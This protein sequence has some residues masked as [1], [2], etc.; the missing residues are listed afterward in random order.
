MRVSRYLDLH[1]QGLSCHTIEQLAAR[2]DKTIA[3]LALQ[4]ITSRLDL[5][6]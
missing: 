4:E 6:A 2:S 3:A 1:A 5:L